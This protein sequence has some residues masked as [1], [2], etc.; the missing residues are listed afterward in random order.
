MSLLDDL[1]AAAQSIDA[2]SQPSSNQVPGI[3]AAL[4]LYTEHGDKFLKAA[5]DGPPAVTAL[6]SGQNPA[7]PADADD[8]ETDPGKPATPGEQ[9]SPPPGK[10]APPAGPV[11]KK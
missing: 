5:E 3:V 1:T 7:E 2:T 8:G 11:G 6:S 4:V 10:Q 9:T